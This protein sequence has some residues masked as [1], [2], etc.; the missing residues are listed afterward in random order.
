M[1]YKGRYFFK[2]NHRFFDLIIHGFSQNVILYYSFLRKTQKLTYYRL[3]SEKNAFP[4]DINSF[5]MFQKALFLV[6]K[7][8]IFFVRIA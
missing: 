1:N 8:C 7:Y 3:F 5:I 2:K 4:I 6:L